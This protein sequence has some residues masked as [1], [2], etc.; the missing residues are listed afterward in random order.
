MTKNVT[1]TITGPGS[2]SGPFTLYFLDGDGATVYQI[3]NIA[4]SALINGGY[5][6]VGI[7]LDAQSVRIESMAGLCQ[8][9]DTTASIIIP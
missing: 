3:N 4:L 1:V 7:P 2:N 5:T 8:G 9:T 6:A